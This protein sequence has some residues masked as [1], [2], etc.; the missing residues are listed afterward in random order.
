MALMLFHAARLDSRIDSRGCFLLMEDQDRSKWDRRLILRASEF[1]D[2]SAEG[3]AVCPFHL[4]AGIAFYHCS[5]K[6]YA[7]T[8][9]PV[10]LRLYDALVAMQ[11]SPIYLLNRAIVVAQIDGPEAGIRALYEAGQEG[12]LRHYHWFDA[13]LGELY[14]RA[15]DMEQAR[16]HL[17]S[18]YGKTS[19]FHDREVIERRLAQC[20]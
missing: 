8:K 7:E 12:A 17:E 18:A 20:R 11:P 2:Q 16:R 1:L 5:A 6:S 19:T 9:W 10:I 4:E 13:T 3:E 14:R 15:G